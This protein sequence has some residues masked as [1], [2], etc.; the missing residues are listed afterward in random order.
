MLRRS[1]HEHR[2]Y[3][4]ARPDESNLTQILVKDGFWFTI[5]IINSEA[6]VMYINI[7][8][9]YFKVHCGSLF[10]DA[11]RSVENTVFTTRTIRPLQLSQ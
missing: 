5:T 1:T 6:L 3:L 7:H 11:L 9:Y 4:P 10:S 2:N 8:N